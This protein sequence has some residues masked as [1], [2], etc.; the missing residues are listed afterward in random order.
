MGAYGT[1]GTFL[2]D[3]KA[4]FS[5]VDLTDYPQPGGGTGSPALI[6]IGGRQSLVIYEKGTFSPFERQSRYNAPNSAS[7]SVI[8]IDSSDGERIPGFDAGPL[9]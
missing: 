3:V 1:P 7:E 8:L 6:I 5:E 2:G 9:S 4:V